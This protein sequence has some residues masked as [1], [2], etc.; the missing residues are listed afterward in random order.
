MRLIQNIAAVVAAVVLYILFVLPVEV[1]KDLYIHPIAEEVREY[2]G[3]KMPSLE[4]MI[5]SIFYSL[6]LFAAVSTLYMYHKFYVSKV[7][8][9]I[10]IQHQPIREQNGAFHFGWKALMSMCFLVLFIPSVIFVGYKDKFKREIPGPIKYT[11]LHRLPALDLRERALNVSAKL[12]ILDQQYI[13]KLNEL[14]K[15]YD[16]DLA[17]F[18]RATKE[19]QTKKSEYD[20]AIQNCRPGILR[21][22]SLEPSLNVITPPPAGSLNIIGPLDLYPSCTSPPFPPLQSNQSFR[23]FWLMPNGKQK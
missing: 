9:E 11:D 15:Q 5:S 19:F 3:F 6:P 20:I 7:I 2:T 12:N 14:K 13:S 22:P 17:D 1:A 10:K 16:K 8:R 18:D 23:S 21:I 4:V